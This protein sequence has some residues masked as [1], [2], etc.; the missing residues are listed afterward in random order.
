MLP[1]DELNANRLE[2]RGITDVVRA[3]PAV[4]MDGFSRYADRSRKYRNAAAGFEIAPDLVFY[5]GPL[6]LLLRCVPESSPF[7]RACLPER[8]AQG[9]RASFQKCNDVLKFL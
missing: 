5:R 6:T 3:R 2:V 7:H 9:G 4:R 1:A 8:R